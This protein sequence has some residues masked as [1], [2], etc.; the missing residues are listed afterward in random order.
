MSTVPLTDEG[1]GEFSSRS[2]ILPQ[3][4][5]EASFLRLLHRDRLT[6]YDQPQPS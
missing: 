5:R 4:D 1:R 6:R 2:V 3:E